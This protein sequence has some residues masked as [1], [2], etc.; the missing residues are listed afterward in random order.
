VGCDALGHPGHEILAVDLA[1]AN[2]HRNRDLAVRRV[3]AG[4]DGGVGDRRVS[5]D[6]YK[7]RSTRSIL[8]EV[9]T[10]DGR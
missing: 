4:D 6:D 10:P 7:K 8:A 2:H 1:P 9:L 3:R 5:P